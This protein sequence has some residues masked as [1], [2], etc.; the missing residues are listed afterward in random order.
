MFKIGDMVVYSVHGLSKII[1]I[2]EKT[3]AG[4]TKMYYVLQPLEQP[5]LT[6][7]TPVDH[8]KGLIFEMMKK[9]EA[10]KILQSFAE[11]GADWVSEVRQRMTKYHQKV[12]SGDRRQIAG[13]LN[14]LMRKNIEASKSKKKLY[15]QD[16]K[17]METI[18]NILYKELAIV[19]NKSFDEIAK[20]TE[21]MVLKQINASKQEIV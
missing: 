1:D 12:K 16:R 6:I 3:I 20:L 7:S 5:S 13:V 17:L 9:D 11:P 4:E 15:D 18:Q 21:K 2:C 8:Q 19:L 10:E 14:T